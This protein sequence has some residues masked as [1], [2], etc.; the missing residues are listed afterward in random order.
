[1]GLP[2]QLFFLKDDQGVAALTAAMRVYHWKIDPTGVLTDKPANE[3]ADECFTEETEVLT[4]FGWK[5]LANITTEEEIMAVKEWNEAFWERP[6][7][8]INQDYDGIAYDLK[9]RELSFTATEHHKHAVVPYGAGRI[10]KNIKKFQKKEVSE[11]P[12]ESFMAVNTTFPWG[13]TSSSS[14]RILAIGI[15]VS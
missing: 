11:L 8:V 10:T 3:G 6:S 15:L 2:P 9:H 12:Y 14:S 4:R 1:M 7:R 5:S 13:N